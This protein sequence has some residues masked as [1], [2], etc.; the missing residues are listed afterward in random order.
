L[1]SASEGLNASISLGGTAI[2]WL[3]GVSFTARRAVESWTSMGS[4]V[5]DD[6]LKGVVEYTGGFSRAY[7]DNTY[8]DIFVSGTALQGT[9]FPRGGSTPYI[10]GTLVI[11]DYTL[12]NMER[13]SATAVVEEGSF[14][15]YGITSS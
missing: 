6:V 7:I 2:G 9:I 14:T 1:S 12:S 5:P 4:T 15:M 13:S 11:S 3:A 10:A 8:F